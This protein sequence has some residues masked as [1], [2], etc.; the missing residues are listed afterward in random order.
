MRKHSMYQ[1][2]Y[3]SFPDRRREFE[4]TA[5][6]FKEKRLTCIEDWCHL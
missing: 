3:A 2:V 6:W 1:M 5:D 4:E